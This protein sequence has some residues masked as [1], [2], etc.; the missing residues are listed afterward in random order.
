MVDP[1]G[2][3]LLSLPSNAVMGLNVPHISEYFGLWSIEEQT[4]RSTVERING[5]NLEAHVREAAS[6]DGGRQDRASYPMVD[7][8]AVITLRGPLMKFVSS[9][10][11]GTS[12]S[13]ARRQ[14][15]EAVA[16]DR[17]KAILLRIDSPGGTVSGTR[18]LAEDVAAANK[19]KPVAAFIEDLG[20]S[21]A[22]WIASQAGQVYANATAIVGSIGTYAVIWDQ[23]VA[24]AQA[25]IIVHVIRAGDLKGAAEPGTPVT[26]ALLDKWQRLVDT[27][28]GFFLKA[29]AKGRGL[30]AA[31]VRNWANGDVWVG[32][33]AQSLG[34]IDGVKTIDQVLRA[35]RGTNSTA[36]TTANIKESQMDTPNNTAVGGD[37]PHTDA[38]PAAASITDL[39][40]AMPKAEPALI[41]SWLQ[42][43]VTLAEAQSEYAQA[44]ETKLEAAIAKTPPATPP[45]GAA[46]DARGVTTP[47][48]DG[49]GYVEAVEKLV[50]KGMSRAKASLQVKRQ[51]PE[52]HRAYVVA[53]NARHGRSVDPF[54]K[55]YG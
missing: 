46:P 23:S 16:D 42:R 29:V 45:L 9:L 24:A 19:Q 38:V 5:I 35:L 13:F 32:D 44:L 12:T 40:T 49:S 34:L 54:L 25:G 41:V 17:V 21:A 43:G 26:Q 51:N 7:N 6:Q 27:L 47:E 20:A 50:D 36:A 8:V 39:K 4:F 10:S 52:L 15:R 37:S 33:Q 28:N 2:D 48:D 14:I 1:Q 18:D 11:P 55:Q 53:Y 31:S 30:S 3:S 22:Y